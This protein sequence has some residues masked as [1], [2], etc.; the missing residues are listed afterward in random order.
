VKFDG[1]ATF[2]GGVGGQAAPDVP[3]KAPVF[4]GVCADDKQTADH[5]RAFG[6]ALAARGWPHRIDEQHVGHMFADVH[7][8]HA[9]SY[10]RGA[11][12]VHDE[13]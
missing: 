13:R 10:L 5:S 6:G 7:V 3:F 2:A 12:K 1:F 8:L 9:V 4:V 11:H